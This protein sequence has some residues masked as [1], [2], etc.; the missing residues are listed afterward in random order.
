[1]QEH[2]STIQRS[3]RRIPSVIIEEIQVGEDTGE[4]EELYLKGEAEGSQMKR[5]ADSEAMEII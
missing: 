5:G 3:Y 2:I 4:H 1:M